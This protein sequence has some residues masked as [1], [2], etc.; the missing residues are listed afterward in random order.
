MKNLQSVLVVCVDRDDDLGKKTGIRGPVIGKKNVL[1]AAVKLAVADPEESDAN[2]MFASVKKLEEVK[3]HAKN[4]EVACL[5]GAGKGGFKSD[6]TV[7]EQLEKVLNDFPAES[8]VLVTDGAEDDQ[9]IP[10]LQ[11]RLTI[12]S[13][14]RI[15]IKQAHQVESTFYTIK[16]ALKDPFVSRIV[17]GVPGLILLLYFLIGSLSLQIVSLILGAYLLV[18]GF[19]IEEMSL[20][21]MEN[22]KNN[23]SI[24]RPSFPFLLGG[25]FIVVFAIITAYTTFIST[26]DID[27][28]TNAVQSIQRTYLL[29]FLA[30]ESFVLGKIVDVLHFKKA[31][32]LPEQGI[33]A[34][35]LLLLWVILDAGTEVFLKRADLNWFLGTILFSFVILLLVFRFTKTVDVRNRVTRLLVGLPVYNKDGLWVGNVERVN[36]E[37]EA[38]EFK[39]HKTKQAKSV[40]K[41]KF[42]LLEGKIVLIG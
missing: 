18:K 11:S 16:E 32:R 6:K 28:L 31:F 30:G 15:V 12:I 20:R 3:G 1:N 38:V 23:F 13:K 17:F 14:Q 25:F 37:K 22:L 7:A 19:G 21:T 40:S 8:L 34:V 2:C 39:E 4:A 27:P 9:V 5:T 42:Q 10:I 26:F 29:F 24:K 36:S 35:S 33:I 41:S